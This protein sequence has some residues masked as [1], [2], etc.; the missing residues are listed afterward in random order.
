MHQI[1]K[2]TEEYIELLKENLIKNKKLIDSDKKEEIDSEINKFTDKIEEY[3]MRKIYKY[4]FPEELLQEDRN[5]YNKT[6]E[7]SWIVPE[8]FEI[9]KLYINQLR[10]ALSNFRKLDEAKS[11]FEKIRCIENAFTNIN[12]SIKFSTG[13]KVTPGQEEVTPI[14][15]FT[16]IKAQPQR[17]ISQLNYIK[18]FRDLSKGGKSAF[19]V[20]QLESAVAF[21][22]NLDHTKLKMTKEEFDKNV[23]EAKNK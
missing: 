7:L 23:K 11:V 20:T 12:N 10:F 16:I 6:K 19:M 14:L 3:I 8:Q 9:K 15:H 17:F 5:F 1:Y 4:V 22:M 2:A 21:I 18:C 13:K